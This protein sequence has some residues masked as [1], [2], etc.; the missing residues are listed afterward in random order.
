MLDVERLR[1]RSNVLVFAAERE[2]RRAGRDLQ[3]SDSR[4]RIDDLF[5]QAIAEPLLIFL[6]AHVGKWQDR[7]RSSSI[8]RSGR[9][10]RADHGSQRAD[11]FARGLE[12]T[13]WCL[14]QAPPY[15]AIDCLVGVKAQRF[16]AKD[17]TDDLR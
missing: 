2:R 9:C 12:P 4:E 11:Q 13:L 14:F 16:V 5:G 17:G 8:Q 15:E 1:D 3:W 6:R 7:D 10:P